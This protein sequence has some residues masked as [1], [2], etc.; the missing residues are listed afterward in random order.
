MAL[1]TA[2]AA[3]SDF[4]PTSL[5]DEQILVRWPLEMSF[6]INV[7]GSPTLWD[8]LSSPVRTGLL[9]AVGSGAAMLLAGRACFGTC[10]AVFSGILSGLGLGLARRGLEITLAIGGTN[11]TGIVGGCNAEGGSRSVKRPEEVRLSDINDM[12]GINVSN[13]DVS[14]VI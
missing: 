8:W 6:L 14:D 1:A 5:L 3:S 10:L 9:T 2:P 7:S 12:L 13:N 4:I 11:G